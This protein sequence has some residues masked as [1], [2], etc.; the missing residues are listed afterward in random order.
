MR[1]VLIVYRLTWKS[2]LREVLVTSK[3]RDKTYEILNLKI[4]YKQQNYKKQE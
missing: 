4:S 3:L 2:Y 1:V